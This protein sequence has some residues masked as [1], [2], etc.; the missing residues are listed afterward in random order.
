MLSLC[1]ISTDFQVTKWDPAWPFEG[2]KLETCCPGHTCP[3]A[4][5][6]GHSFSLSTLRRAVLQKNKCQYYS[7][8][9]TIQCKGNSVRDNIGFAENL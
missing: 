4:S 1:G 2:E 7:L 5:E 8:L 9:S 6:V 3:Q